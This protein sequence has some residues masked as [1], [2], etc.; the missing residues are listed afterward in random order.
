MEKLPAS[1]ALLEMVSAIAKQ[2]AQVS[3]ALAGQLILF[4]LMFMAAWRIIVVT[5]IK[6]TGLTV[7]RMNSC[8]SSE[9]SY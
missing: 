2:A 6:K 7:L 5:G 3:N 8:G 4:A 1:R 9:E